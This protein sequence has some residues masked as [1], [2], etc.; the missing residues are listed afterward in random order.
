MSWPRG[1][2]LAFR[3]WRPEMLLNRLQHTRQPLPSLSPPTPP[4]PTT[5]SDAAPNVRPAVP[6]RAPW[7]PARAAAPP[8]S[9]HQELRVPHQITQHRADSSSPA[10]PP[11]SVASKSPVLKRAA[12]STVAVQSPCQSEGRRLHAHPGSG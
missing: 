12:V 6:H 9:A 10:L 3:R 2:L 4:P 7:S 5:R 11:D 8:G 1:V